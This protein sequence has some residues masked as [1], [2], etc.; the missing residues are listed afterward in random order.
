MVTAAKREQGLYDVS[1]SLSVFDGGTLAER[2]IADLV[3]VGKFVPNLNITTFSAGHTSS[4]NPFIR[5]IGTQDHL[6][7]TDPG[8][9]V[10]V[11]GVYLGRQVGQHW[12]LTNIERVEVLRG[13]QGTL[14]GRNS[15]GGAVNIVTAAPRVE[16]G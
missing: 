10:Y 4:A 1:A 9:G 16:S 6:I 11:D 15:I 14:Y 2:G 8:V 3:D 12:N 5:G 7:T 13:P